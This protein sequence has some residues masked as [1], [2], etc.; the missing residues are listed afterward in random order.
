MYGE[1]RIVFV[2]YIK[3]ECS[4]NREIRGEVKKEWI[5][6]VE[7][8]KSVEMKEVEVMKKEEEI[9]ENE[10]H[11]SKRSSFEMNGRMIRCSEGC[12]TWILDRELNSV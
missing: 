4:E 10:V 11:M 7:E 5:E 2:R 3:M 12:Q 6:S 1:A 8:W 9:S